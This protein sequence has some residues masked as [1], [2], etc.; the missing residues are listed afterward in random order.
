MLVACSR[1]FDYYWTKIHIDLF[2]NLACTIGVGMWQAAPWTLSDKDW[3][4]WNVPQ[5]LCQHSHQLCWGSFLSVQEGPAPLSFS[6]FQHKARWCLLTIRRLREGLWGPCH[7]WQLALEPLAT[8]QSK[9]Q[10]HL[11]SSAP[12]FESSPPV[13]SQSHSTVCTHMIRLWIWIFAQRQCIGRLAM[14]T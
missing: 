2:L 6:T 13:S 12:V 8:L 10:P 9:V 1:S 14:H 4:G 3:R 11:P 5:R 7:T